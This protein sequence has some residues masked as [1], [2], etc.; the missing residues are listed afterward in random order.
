MNQYRSIILG[1]TSFEQ[2]FE[3][4]TDGLPDKANE[5][6]I[7][8]T[9][10]TRIVHLPLN[11]VWALNKIG[12]KFFQLEK[13]FEREPT[14]IELAKELAMSEYEI[15]ETIR[16]SGSH[17]SLDSPIIQGKNT[18]LLDILPNEQ[19]VPPDTK[20]IQESLY[21]EI[22]RALRFLS[23][24]EVYVVKLFFG[25]DQQ[26]LSLEEIGEKINLTDE[27]AR[28][29]KEKAIRYLRHPSRS[30]YLRMF[31]DEF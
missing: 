10:R 12:K 14:L 17:L 2:A 20:L 29:I 31:L 25:L 26:A 6:S 23:E 7:D 11:W 22:K 21:L 19:L 30:K 4:M 16:I 18:C 27:R 24:R 8:K 15:L 1:Y 9:E 13:K 28:Q 3:Q 5:N